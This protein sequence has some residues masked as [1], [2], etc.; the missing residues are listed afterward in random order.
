MSE[1]SFF[2]K[3]SSTQ[4]SIFRQTPKPPTP[5]VDEAFL[6]RTE[7]PSFHHSE[8]PFLYYTVKPIKPSSQP[9]PEYHFFVAQHINQDDRQESFFVNPTPPTSIGADE[10]MQVVLP[11]PPVP[12]T[13]IIF[14]FDS[15]DSGNNRPIFSN[16]MI[17]PLIRPPSSIFSEIRA[18]NHNL[19]PVLFPAQTTV[20]VPGN[21]F[22]RNKPGAGVFVL[23]VG[24]YETPA[25][26]NAN[27]FR[28]SGTVVLVQDSGLNILVDTGSANSKSKLL[29]GRGKSSFQSTY[30]ESGIENSNL[31]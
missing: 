17:T 29:G 7:P 20:L 22:R 15:N 31:V 23:V 5:V 4:E 9:Q 13:T 12:P 2:E 27:T 25:E 19:H 26:R 24:E 11:T 1:G 10:A 8:E 28:Y 18:P 30:L 14:P 6:H 21:G 3:S 16:N